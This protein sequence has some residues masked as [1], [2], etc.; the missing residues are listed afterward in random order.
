ML[1][2]KIIQTESWK[3]EK[4]NKISDAQKAR[5]SYEHK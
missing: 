2:K 3:I 4:E 1:K 5:M